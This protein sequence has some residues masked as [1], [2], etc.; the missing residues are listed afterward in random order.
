MVKLKT[1][2]EILWEVTKMII[3]KQKAVFK[4]A[5]KGKTERDVYWDILEDDWFDYLEK[6]LTIEKKQCMYCEKIVDY[7]SGIFTCGECSK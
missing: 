1:K 5:S 4:E 2:S 6:K 3:K 7:S